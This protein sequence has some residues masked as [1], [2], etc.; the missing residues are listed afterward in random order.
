[1]KLKYLYRF[2]SFKSWVGFTLAEVLITLGIIGVVVAI[3]IPTLVNQYEVAQYRSAFK[4]NFAVISQA[5]QKMLNDCNVT[6]YSQLNGTICGANPG[7]N[8]TGI[9]LYHFPS[10]FKTAEV[11]TTYSLWNSNCKNLQNLPMDLTGNAN[12][13]SFILADGSIILMQWVFPTGSPNLTYFSIYVDLN[14]YDR[15]NVMG[16]DIQLIYV[17]S[18]RVI[19][20][21]S[22]ESVIPASVESSCALNSNGSGCAVKLLLDKPL[23]Y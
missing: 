12:S 11:S 21:G 14:G 8:A 3:T 18:N 20:A 1:M 4:K 13:S 16:K 7:Y 9:M 2:S 19:A 15:P 10:Y 17:L 22:S 6:D 23:P 5:Y